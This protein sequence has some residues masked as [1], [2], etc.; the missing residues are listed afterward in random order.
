MSYD[1]VRLQ[2]DIAQVQH[3]DAGFGTGRLVAVNLVLT[4]AH[5]LWNEQRGTGPLLDNWQVR[6][7]RDRGAG[8]WCFRGGN[9][10]VWYN[11]E[12]DLALIQLLDPEGGALRPELRLRVATVSR[13]NSHSVEARGYPRASKQ[14]E[15]P[16]ELIP[17]LGRL[18]AGQQDR[19]LRFGVDT[20][21]LPNE[22]H[23]DWPGMSGSVVFLRDGHDQDEIWVY[24]V[25][26]A[27][28]EKFNGQLAVARLAEAWRD[29]GFRRLLVAAGA[30]DQD[31]ED[32][33]LDDVGLANASIGRLLGLTRDVPAAADAVSRSREAIE[34]TYRQLDQLELV[35]M[36]HDALHTVEFECLRPMEAAGPA[37]LTRPHR[38]KFAGE[39]RKIL[40]GIREREMRPELRDE[41]VERLES[42]A[43]AFR[44]AVDAPSET[45]LTSVIG[46]LNGLLASVSP[47]LDVTIET[48]ASEL[49]LDR[50]IALMVAVQGML[51]TATDA[52]LDGTVKDFVEGIDVLRSMQD[53]LSRRVREHG[54]LQRLDSELRLICVAGPKPKTLAKEWERVKRV[55]SKLVPPHSAVLDEANADLK[56]F[57]SDIEA[58]VARNDEQAA[59]NHLRAYF[60]SVSSVFQN[61]DSG[62]KEFTL[63]LSELGPSLRAILTTSD[64]GGGKWPLRQP[65]L[66]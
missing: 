54:L 21:D 2:H 55:R 11:R 46:E 19:P 10:V 31:A 42:S 47:K 7:A 60:A 50:V 40:E 32:P 41:L 51:P 56:A 48:A 34:N 16:R 28:P 20:C 22:P 13:S 15:G 57:E 49:R 12:V 66:T 1:L 45:A 8:A 58:A 35:K 62:L 26:Q 5:T 6:I 25:V 44:E 52:T 29:S 18:T 53:E 27:V 61:V 4:A 37:C 64:N 43:E 59:L 24:G 17:V 23:A 38:I 63:E 39:R 30:P 9:R 65:L 3:V 14:A 36:V 33:S